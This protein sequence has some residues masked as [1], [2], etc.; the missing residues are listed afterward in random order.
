M[1]GILLHLAHYASIAQE[2]VA[3]VSVSV[4][5]RVFQYLLFIDRPR[6][7]LYLKN[8]DWVY[9][10]PS[11]IEHATL[12]YDATKHCIRPI[13]YE[14]GFARYPWLAVVDEKGTDISEFF[15]TLRIGRGHDIAAEKV[16]RLFVQQKK[17]IPAGKLT[18][19]KRNGD[20]IE[21]DG[22]TGRTLPSYDVVDVSQVDFVR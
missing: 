22:I 10:S 13:A 5:E 19:T 4:Q 7:M 16:M 6:D 20:T 21:V 18:V 11:L 2:W 9:H 17:C 14:G 12:L 8:G 3:G 15:S 1:S